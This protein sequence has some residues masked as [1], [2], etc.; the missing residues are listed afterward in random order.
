MEDWA[1]ASDSDPRITAAAV[2]T[3]MPL[4]FTIFSL[5]A[6]ESGDGGLLAMENVIRVDWVSPDFFDTVGIPLVEGSTFD[7]RLAGG[8]SRS[9]Q[10]KSG[11]AALG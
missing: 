1:D 5:D 8:P 6:P 7:P 9:R 4:S 3:A 10:R 2:A 11:Q